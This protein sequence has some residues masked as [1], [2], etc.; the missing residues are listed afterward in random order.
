MKTKQLEFILNDFAVSE[1]AKFKCQWKFS[2]CRV[3]CSSNTRTYPLVKEISCI[4]IVMITTSKVLQVH[5]V[6]S[7]ICV[8]CSETKGPTIFTTHV[9]DLHLPFLCYALCVDHWMWL[10]DWKPATNLWLF[11]VVKVFSH[12]L[13]WILG[14]VSYLQAWFVI[15]TM[16]LLWKFVVK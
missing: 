2:S 15:L 7:M 10:C 5:V 1:I 6:N 16:W 4:N 13:Q 9:R 11:V 12:L 14:D 3:L 8:Y